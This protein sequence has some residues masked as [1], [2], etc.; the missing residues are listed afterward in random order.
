LYSQANVEFQE[1][2]EFWTYLYTWITSAC[3]EVNA[4]HVERYALRDVVRARKEPG[5]L[6]M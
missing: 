2:A 5:Y 6:S 3:R 4:G 1:D